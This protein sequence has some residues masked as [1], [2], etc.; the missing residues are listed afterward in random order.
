[1]FEVSKHPHQREL[2]VAEFI[3][4]FELL[5]NKLSVEP[6]QIIEAWLDKCMHLNENILFLQNDK[7]L[8]GVFC[9]LD[10]NGFAKIKVNNKVKSYNSIN[11]I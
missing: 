9:G 8:E 7:I 11:L 4:S 10:D 2:I 5:L 1:M 3:N 6:Y